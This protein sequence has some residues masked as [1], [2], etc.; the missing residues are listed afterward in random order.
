MQKEDVIWK[1]GSSVI[2]RDQAF[3]GTNGLLYTVTNSY[4][5]ALKQT[6][7]ILVINSFSAIGSFTYSCSCNIYSNRNDPLCDA[8][9]KSSVTL[10]GFNTT[11]K[12][13]IL[14][15]YIIIS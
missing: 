15:F 5:S 8:N 9:T 3:I 12:S 11:G 7:T 1:L 4:N 2:Y 6:T 10:V 13:K 14:L